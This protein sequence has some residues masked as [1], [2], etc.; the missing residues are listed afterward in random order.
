LFNR[1]IVKIYINFWEKRKEKN[2]DRL[3]GGMERETL[4][5]AKSWECMPFWSRLKLG[6]RRSIS[7][8]KHQNDSDSSSITNKIGDSKSLIPWEK[9][10]RDMNIQHPHYT[11]FPNRMEKGPWMYSLDILFP[12]RKRQFSTRSYLFSEPGWEHMRQH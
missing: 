7:A 10:G 9:K 11:H 2:I 1:W 8:T 3:V 12:N 4:D 5:N 6:P